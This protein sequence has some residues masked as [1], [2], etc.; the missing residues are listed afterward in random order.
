MKQDK[1]SLSHK[2][3]TL[4]RLCFSIWLM[5]FQF[6]RISTVVL[7]SD[8]NIKLQIYLKKKNLSLKTI[9]DF[10]RMKMKL[11]MKSEKQILNVTNSISF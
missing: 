10:K 11:L 4:F 5:G 1:G 2:F 6:S 8:K 9:K 3:L 7:E